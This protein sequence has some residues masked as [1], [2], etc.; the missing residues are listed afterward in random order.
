[1]LTSSRLPRAMDTGIRQRN[2]MY[3]ECASCL[4]GV[5]N[6]PMDSPI[7]ASLMRP[8][9]AADVCRPEFELSVGLGG[10]H[11]NEAPP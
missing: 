6:G 2:H 4:P 9:A 3:C 11:I 10:V 8:K 7:S 5:L 1:M